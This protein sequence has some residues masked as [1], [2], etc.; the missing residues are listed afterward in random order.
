MYLLCYQ[1]VPSS[2]LI[3]ICDHE[4]WMCPFEYCFLFPDKL[5]RLVLW[6]I[7]HTVTCWNPFLSQSSLSGTF[8]S[9]ERCAGSAASDLLPALSRE[10][11]GTSIFCFNSVSFVQMPAPRDE[12]VITGLNWCGFTTS[13]DTSELPPPHCKSPLLLFALYF[14]RY[15]LLLW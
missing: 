12:A 13:D 7:I 3:G 6:R 9:K 14:C 5:K 11:R 8:L 15:W 10:R 4:D 1:R 2:F